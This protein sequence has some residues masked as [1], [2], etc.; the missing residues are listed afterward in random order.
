MIYLSLFLYLLAGASILALVVSLD[1]IG[2]SVNDLSEILQM[3][4]SIITV[5][6]DNKALRLIVVLFWPIFGA[7]SIRNL[8]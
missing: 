2:R 5:P 8:F 4:R 6:L 7:A 3:D 1:Q